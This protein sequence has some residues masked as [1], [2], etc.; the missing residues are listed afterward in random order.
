M[1]SLAATLGTARYEF[2]MQVRRWSLWVVVAA[3]SMVLLR[4]T[5]DQWS[6][7]STGLISAHDV[8]LL[9]TSIFQYFLP[10]AFGVL[11]ADRWVR[12][13][14]TRVTELLE[15]LPSGDGIRLV[16]KYVGSMLATALPLACI[17]FAG[18]TAIAWRG[19]ALG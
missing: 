8:V 1:S 2:A 13:D 19:A 5:W 16:G 14:R 7:L 6:R 15:T 11:L 10:V 4:Y 3:F 12:D 9:W 18:V 17:Y